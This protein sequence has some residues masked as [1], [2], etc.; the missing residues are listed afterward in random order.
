[1]VTKTRTLKLCGVALLRSN[2]EMM[3]IMHN[4]DNIQH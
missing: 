1:M 3:Y 2:L 4:Q